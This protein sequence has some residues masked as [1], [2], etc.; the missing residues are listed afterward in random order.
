MRTRPGWETRLVRLAVIPGAQWRITMIKDQVNCN[1]QRCG[2]IVSP[3]VTLVC[4]TFSVTESSQSYRL[5]PAGQMV[6][7]NPLAVKYVKF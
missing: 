4:T 6:G 5:L 3:A 7:N 2:G 1:T